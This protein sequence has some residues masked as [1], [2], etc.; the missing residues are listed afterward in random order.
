MTTSETASKSKQNHVTIQILCQ[1]DVMG[2]RP[3][4]NSIKNPQ[5]HAEV[6]RNAGLEDLSTILGGNT[7]KEGLE[8]KL[9]RGQGDLSVEM[10]SDGLM[11]V[12]DCG[13]SVNEKL[14]TEVS[15]RLT[16][17]NGERLMTVESELRRIAGAFSRSGFETGPARIIISRRQDQVDVVLYKY[18][19]PLVQTPEPHSEA[20]NSMMD[21]AFER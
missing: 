8:R 21:L 6:F 14:E 3:A 10:V 19:L 17:A 5:E 7:D 20:L 12:F 4:A 18:Q 1:M 13:F 2:D 9:T 15:A 11:L 16:K